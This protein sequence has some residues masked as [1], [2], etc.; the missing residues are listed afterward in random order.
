[1][2]QHFPACPT[3][4]KVQEDSWYI[5]EEQDWGQSLTTQLVSTALCI[6]WAGSSGARTC[7][8]QRL[9]ARFH[10]LL[11]P[12]NPKAWKGNPKAEITPTLRTG[13]NHMESV[14][15]RTAWRFWDFLLELTDR[16][17]YKTCTS[18]QTRQPPGHPSFEV[19]AH[20]PAAA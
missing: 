2:W 12:K 11:C 17:P 7:S 18:G 9:R 10:T 15:Y 8:S 4:W 3:G 6:S 20:S 19:L 5:Q 1:M 13:G 14:S 16:N